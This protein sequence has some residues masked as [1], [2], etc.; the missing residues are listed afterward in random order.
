[1][2]QLSATTAPS[3]A[4][5]RITSSAIRELLAVADRPGVIS[6]A[7]GLPS[8][9]HFPTEEA[10]EAI[11]DVLRNDRGALQYSSTEGD[12]GLREWVAARHGARTEQ[13]LITHGSQQ[14]LDLVARV[15]LDV[16]DPVALADPGYI[17]AIQ[18]MRLSGGRLVALPTD[19]H[20]LSVETLEEQI[21]AG[22]RPR[23]VYLVPNF[24]NPT[25]ATLSAARA[26][27]LARLA[28]QH[29]FLIVEDNPYGEIRF[30]GTAPPSLSTLTDNVVT[31]GTI[32][33]TLFPGLRVGWIVAPVWLAPSLAL[34]KQ[35]VDLHTATLTQK[36]ALRL[37]TRPGFLRDHLTVLRSH[38]SSQARILTEALATEL[39]ESLHVAPAEGGMFLWA[40]V[41]LPDIDTQALLDVAIDHGVAYVPGSAFSVSAAHRSHLRLSYATVSPAE[42]VEGAR[43]LAGVILDGPERSRRRPGVSTR[44]A[45]TSR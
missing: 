1:M 21:G 17:G 2:N 5:R 19:D 7:G 4:A 34:V 3:G 20:G 37:L 13:V 32:S 25:G 28:D 14:A 30:A 15:T 36:V 43:R 26:R 22:L 27:R 38:Y 45:A 12:P 9:L 10:S 18:A 6:L 31:V 35:A 8:A 29:G 44:P 39:G 16:D 33:K 24:H 40:R 41:R 11:D 42:L 23:L